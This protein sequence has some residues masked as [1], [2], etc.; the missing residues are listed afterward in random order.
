MQWRATQPLDPAQAD[1]R[2]FVPCISEGPVH[3]MKIVIE[4]LAVP[5]D[6]ES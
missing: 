3:L 5:L 6:T 1:V 2:N 4:R